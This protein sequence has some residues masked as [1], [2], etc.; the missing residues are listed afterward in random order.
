M[1]DYHRGS[2]T[3]WA[4][5]RIPPS[6]WISGV[7]LPIKSCGAF[8]G[9]LSYSFTLI[10]SEICLSSRISI[11]RGLWFSVAAWCLVTLT[12]HVIDSTLNISW[13]KWVV[14]CV[15]CRTWGLQSKRV[16][17]AGVKAVVKLFLLFRPWKE[18]AIFNSWSS[19]WSLAYLTCQPGTPASP[20]TKLARI[21]RSAFSKWMRFAKGSSNLQII[22][23]DGALH[24]FAKSWGLRLSHAWLFVASWSET[25]Q[26]VCREICI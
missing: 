21:I 9:E 4:F 18:R 3:S 2:W 6:W 17:K 26:C 24:I 1:R 14:S 23:C 15:W 5:T 20:T 8:L 12:V 10:T 11:S 19:V 22:F 16:I 25:D 7:G 13:E